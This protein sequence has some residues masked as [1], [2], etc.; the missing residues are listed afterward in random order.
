MSDYPNKF[1][2]KIVSCQ[3]HDFQLF[4]SITLNITSANELMSRSILNFRWLIS[5]IK[6]RY[7][8]IE[9][10]EHPLCVTGTHLN[11][12]PPA[13][14]CDGH[15]ELYSALEL[16][17]QLRWPRHYTFNVVDF[18]SLESEIPLWSIVSVVCWVTTL[19][20]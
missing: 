19:K 18:Y 16:G 20:V 17:A 14:V 8:D 5:L 2:V 9:K 3:K 4:L 10:I 11:P 1:I 7:L 6:H 12:I 13:R 15:G